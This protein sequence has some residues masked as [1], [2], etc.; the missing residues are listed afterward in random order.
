MVLVGATDGTINV[1]QCGICMSE[2]KDPAKALGI[3]LFI[4][5]IGTF[6]G[7]IIY[8]Y[9][10]FI[11]LGFTVL[12]LNI[13]LTFS[14]ICYTIICKQFDKKKLVDIKRTLFGS[15]KVNF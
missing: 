14:W 10:K 5:S 13:F 8:S 3:Y 7:C 6:V 2:F 1:L 12:F 9:A 4:K 15:L 11:D